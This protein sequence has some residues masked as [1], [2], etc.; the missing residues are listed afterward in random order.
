[1]K[2]TPSG[3]DKHRK[4][5]VQFAPGG[6]AMNAGTIR[7]MA[8]VA[9]IGVFCILGAI[10]IIPPFLKWW[11]RRKSKKEKEIASDAS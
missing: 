2:T 5:T 11:D 6:A 1:L 4:I 7:A 3:G 8:N 9:V 10:I